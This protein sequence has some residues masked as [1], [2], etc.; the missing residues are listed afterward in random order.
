MRDFPRR[1]LKSLIAVVA[2]NA[3]YFLL[4]PYMP[5]AARH[6]RNQLDLGLLVDFWFCLVAYGVLELI[7]RAYRRRG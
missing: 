6:Q 3:A 1:L 7:L 2:G 5:A 4:M